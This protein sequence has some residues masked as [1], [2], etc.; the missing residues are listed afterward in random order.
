MLNQDGDPQQGDEGSTR[1]AKPG[2]TRY[3][4]RYEPIC[5]F[6]KVVC[7]DLGLP[8]AVFVLGSGFLFLLE[9]PLAGYSII[10]AVFG[11]LWERRY[12]QRK[13]KEA[14]IDKKR[15]LLLSIHANFELNKGKAGQI[16]EMGV[17][18]PFFNLLPLDSLLN[19]FA[20]EFLDGSD[21][22]QL[23]KTIQ[24]AFFE[25]IHLFRQTDAIFQRYHFGGEKL[26]ETQVAIH[27]ITDIE[28]HETPRTQLTDLGKDSCTQANLAKSVAKTL[29]TAMS[30]I[31]SAIG[32][33]DELVSNSMEQ[34]TE[35]G[36]TASDD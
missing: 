8:T 26:E 20:A 27:A 16:H 5:S 14:H 9:A 18:V 25:M 17:R 24:N 4:I 35:E 13:E 31:A 7:S 10:F 19:R 6:I 22:V 12:E 34:S 15:G 11:I 28:H 36:S 21:D 32:I 23:F 2:K 29:N 1:K 30:A 33:E 3:S